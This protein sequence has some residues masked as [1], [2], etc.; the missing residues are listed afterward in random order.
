MNSGFAILANPTG[1]VDPSDY[2]PFPNV[3]ICS[4]LII[5]T[6]YL[7]EVGSVH[8]FL[9]GQGEVPLIWI[10]APVDQNRTSWRYVVERNVAVHSSFKVSPIDVFPMKVFAGGRLIVELVRNS[11]SHVEITSLDLS[12]IGLN[13]VGNKNGLSVGSNHMSQNTMMGGRSF[14]S[15]NS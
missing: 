13:I 2:E 8:P 7:L 9:I 12:P 1:L 10:A 4:N 3:T 14:I 15:V 5:E 11:P 6:R